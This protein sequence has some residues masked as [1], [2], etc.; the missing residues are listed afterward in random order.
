M[1]HVLFNGNLFE[2]LRLPFTLENG[3]P[4]GHWRTALFHNHRWF[5]YDD[6]MLPVQ[7][8]ELP[9]DIQKQASLLWLISR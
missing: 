4:S 1:R 3:P 7:Y 6:G 8:P 5:A 2:S 9:I